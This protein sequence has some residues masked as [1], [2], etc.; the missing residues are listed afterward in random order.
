[1][2]DSVKKFSLMIAALVSSLSISAEAQTNIPALIL[3]KG[4]D[5]EISV[6]RWEFSK[7]EIPEGAILRAAKGSNKPLELII[8]GSFHLHGKIIAQ[9]WSSD[10]GAY[11]IRSSSGA[12]ETLTI[13]NTN[14]G[15]RGGG[16]AAGPTQGGRGARGT[17]EYGG[18]GGSGG[19][20]ATA[21][22]DPGKVNGIDAIDDQGARTPVAHCGLKGT[23]GGLRQANSNGGVVFIEVGGDFDGTNGSFE[24]G[25]E[26]GRQG[27][28]GLPAAH[29]STTCAAGGGGAGGGGPGG[30]GGILIVK[31]N[32]S[33]LGYPALG[34]KGGAGGVA[35]KTASEA[36][37]AS[38]GQPGASG[39]VRW[40]VSNLQI[41]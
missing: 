6:Q 1:V 8:R 2:E 28:D 38:D 34:L 27:Q 20:N 37:P 9:G 22:G 39:W 7:L 10:E 23:N 14:R 32:G 29:T 18:G 36:S 13:K 5:R 17:T 31:V 24:M 25:G 26:D 3:N 19:V 33:V 30:Q 41:H 16:G 15:G 4:E 21:Y 40:D 11:E 35:G 12:V